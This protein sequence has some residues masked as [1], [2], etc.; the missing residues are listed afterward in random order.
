MWLNFHVTEI[1]LPTTVASHRLQSKCVSCW[2]QISRA[3]GGL[4]DKVRTLLQWDPEAR[5]GGLYSQTPYL[6]TYGSG[7]CMSHVFSPSTNVCGGKGALLP[8]LPPPLRRAPAFLSLL[9][10]PLLS[11]S[12]P[13]P[14]PQSRLRG[15]T[16]ELQHCVV[17]PIWRAVRWR[18]VHNHNE[19][20]L[21]PRLC[22]ACLVVSC[23]AFLQSLLYLGEVDGV[24]PPSDCH[25]NI[26][27]RERNE[28]R[29][30]KRIQFPCLK[31]FR[32]SCV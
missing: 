5:W 3:R 9:T 16:E 12:P 24:Y 15:G 31:I 11:L 10:H 27:G 32:K 13:P 2:S 8:P 28:I 20:V 29:V 21:N 25:Q 22:L 4:V 18:K 14:N 23:G 1:L 17:D 30:R 26:A 19:A 6:S 7:P